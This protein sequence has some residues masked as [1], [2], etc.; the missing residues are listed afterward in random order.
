M[1]R[2]LSYSPIR[3]YG[4]SIAEPSSGGTILWDSNSLEISLDTQNRRLSGVVPYAMLKSR[5]PTR[6]LCLV[7]RPLSTVRF[8]G[9]AQSVGIMRKDQ[10]HWFNFMSTLSSAPSLLAPFPGVA[11]KSDYLQVDLEAR[12]S[13]LKSE[14]SGR[15]EESARKGDAFHSANWELSGVLN[16]NKFVASIITRM[17][18]MNVSMGNAGPIDMV[19]VRKMVQIVVG[20]LTLKDQEEPPPEK[21]AAAKSDKNAVNDARSWPSM[22]PPKWNVLGRRV[23]KSARKRGAFP[24]SFFKLM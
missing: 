5:S 15:S 3:E 7:H 6:E 19:Q 9:R 12:I 4:L 1:Q 22:T 21:A 13:A 11:V 17:A 10:S 2:V 23:G 16:E 18:S 20:R 14:S 8:Y 24:Q